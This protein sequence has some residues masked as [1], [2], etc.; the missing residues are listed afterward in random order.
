MSQK[1]S[2]KCSHLVKT[3]AG[4]LQVEQGRPC[5]QLPLKLPFPA[6]K[7]VSCLDWPRRF[8]RL[9]LPARKA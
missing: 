2:F 8:R 3:Q 5:S 1:G 4:P 9:T 7:E 6:W